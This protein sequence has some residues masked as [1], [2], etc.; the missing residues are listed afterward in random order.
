MKF[1]IFYDFKNNSLEN[2]KELFIYDFGSI[3]V[4]VFDN[5]V[6]VYKILDKKD[7]FEIVEDYDGY[8]PLDLI[9]LEKY[10]CT[11]N[12]KIYT[13]ETFSINV[14]AY[15][16]S[17]ATIFEPAIIPPPLYSLEILPSRLPS[18]LPSQLPSRRPSFQPPLLKDPPLQTLQNT[19][20]KKVFS[21]KKQDLPPLQEK[22][23]K[24][25][26]EYSSLQ[27]PSTSWISLDQI[28]QIHQQQ[29]K[30]YVQPRPP[31]PSHSLSKKHQNS[32]HVRQHPMQSS[33]GHQTI[34]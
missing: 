8:L 6:D 14:Q 22:I 3:K 29:I 26:K 5:S 7:N 19:S 27:D 4:F 13:T 20:N 16:D 9:S 2:T 34:D 11:F 32:L 33:K 23:P 1:K 31:Y 12:N 18:Q 30:G 10:Q 28:S 15:L 24:I 17:Q 25:K 21:Q